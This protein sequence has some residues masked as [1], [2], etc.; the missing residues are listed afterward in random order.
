MVKFR[1]DQPE[2]LRNRQSF[3]DFSVKMPIRYSVFI[4]LGSIHTKIRSDYTLIT[5]VLRRFPYANCKS[6]S[7]YKP[8]Q[9][10][11]FRKVCNIQI[12]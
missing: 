3:A 12:F 9:S 11:H 4:E 8:L 7:K 1:Q 6:L 2:L 10:V 5:C